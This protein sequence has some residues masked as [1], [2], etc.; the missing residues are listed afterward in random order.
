MGSSVGERKNKFAVGGVKIEKYPVVFDMAVS[1]SLKI[2]GERMVFVLRRQGVF[3]GEGANNCGN[4][5][6]VLTPLE[7][8]FEALLIMGLGLR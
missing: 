3:H 4:L 2:A 5:I 8:L 7:H 6:Y 1:W